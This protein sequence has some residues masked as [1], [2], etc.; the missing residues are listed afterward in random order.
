[1]IDGKLVDGEAGTF[2]NINPATEEVLGEVADAS[3]A[4]MHR[5]IDAARR[6]FDET[7]WATNHAFRQRCLLQLQEALESEQEELREELI[8]EVG[9]PRA[10]THGPQLDAPL[11]DA[12]RYPAKLI[13][14][15]PVGDIA[16]RRAG[17][18]HRR[19]HHPNGLART[20]WRGRRDRAV[21]LPVRGHHPEDRP[22]PGDGQHRRVEA[23]TEHAVQRDP[24]WPVDRRE[25]RHPS[26]CGECRYRVG[27]FRRRGT[28]AV[29]EGRP[30][31][32]HRFH[33]R[34]QADHGEGRGDDE[35]PVPRTR[36]QVGDDRARGRRFRAGLHDGHRAVHARRPG[37]RQPDPVA[38]AAVAL[39][40]GR[41]DPQGDLRGRRGRRPAG[42]RHAVR[43]GHL[44]Q[45]AQPNSRLHPEGSR[46]G[47]DAARRRGRAS[48]MGSTR[49]SSS[50]QRFS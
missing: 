20:R 31:L 5:A 35:A 37:L 44:R 10:I 17:L 45:A 1:M 38:A 25:D 50:S 13:D 9:C 2:T 39:R 8:L 19:E 41:R 36:R 28:H 7:D 24:A 12:L 47:R 29:A 46:R 33:G 3:K 22:G 49:D 6:A 40:R 23:G 14:E 42:S 21:E 11:A 4:D 16:G 48:R 43:S 30:D 15:Y 27:P 18:G 26:G 34:R 32:L